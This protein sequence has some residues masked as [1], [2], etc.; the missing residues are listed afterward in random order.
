[1]VTGPA[2]GWGALRD[3]ISGEVVLPASSTYHAVR[4][5]AIANFHGFRPQAVVRCQTS[6]DVS[7]TVS[8]ARRH[9]LHVVPRS[10]GHCFAGRSSTEGIVV[11]VSPMDSVSVSGDGVAAVGAG[12][13]LGGVYDVLDEHG[14][15]IPAGCGPSVGIAGLTLGGGLGILG[16][17]H[18]L[19]SDSLLAA[20]VV[21]ADGRVVGCDGDREPDLFWAL[22]GSGGGNFGV[23]TSLVFETVPAPA[24]TAFHLTWPH[25]HAAAVVDAWQHWAPAAPDEM[26]ASLLLVAPGNP[27]RPPVVNAFGAMLGAASDTEELLEDFVARA[28]ADPGRAFLR[29][30]RYRDVKRY[31]AELGDD[32]AGEDDRL[33]ED[34]D[35]PQGRLHSKSEY[36]RRPLPREAV[37]ALIENFSEGRVAGES[38]ELDFTPWGGA[39]NRVPAEATAFAHRDELFLIQH[40]AVT[41]P[42]ASAAKT[43]E[44]RRWPGRSWDLARPWGSG[45]VYPNWPDPDLEGWTDTYH[46]GNLHRLVE[47]KRRY[48]PD[49]F[50]RFHQSVPRRA[51]RRGALSNDG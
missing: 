22:R 50:F 51:P 48:D 27:D 47:I 6:E 2:P 5:P 25:L 26:S 21:L 41:D 23:V 24:A 42:G 11:D 49:G 40:V 15:A 3:S 35:E 12:A 14:L 1:V 9:G 16:R 13:R 44:A 19:T 4:K 10:G 43:D 37:E 38:R 29:H 39:Y 34:P 7:E 32:M 28:G 17:K 30:M 8:F 18:G 31:L 33:G 45:G 36:F 20:R 46:G